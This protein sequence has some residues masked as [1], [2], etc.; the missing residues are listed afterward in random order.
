MDFNLIEKLAILKAIDEVIQM[1]E[2]IRK[3]EAIYKELGLGD[4]SLS[5]GKLIEAMAAHPILIERP[6]VI[7]EDKARLGRPPEAVLEIL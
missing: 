2:V 1:D 5:D 4:A 7:K 3:G 6:I